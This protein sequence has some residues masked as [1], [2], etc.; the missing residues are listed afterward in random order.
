MDYIV[1]L[2]R[3]SVNPLTI[4]YVL[5]ANVP[6][7]RQPYFADAT[8]TSM[9]KNIAAPDLAALRAGQVVERG[10]SDVVEGRTVAQI[11]SGLIAEQITFQE[12]VNTDG[13][14]NPYKYYGTAWDG[15]VWVNG[16][17]N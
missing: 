12:Q 3:T 13:E 17:V 5:R 6:T 2:E 10:G 7:A 16:G 8:K 9:Y 11:K 4:R 15:T 14:M 1:I